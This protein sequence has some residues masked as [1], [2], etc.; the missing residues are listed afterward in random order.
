MKNEC[1]DCVIYGQLHRACDATFKIAPV[2][3]SLIISTTTTITSFSKVDYEP[4]VYI[5]TPTHTHT[6][7]LS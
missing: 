6:L 4:M 3:A 1:M 2:S 5:Y 7:S